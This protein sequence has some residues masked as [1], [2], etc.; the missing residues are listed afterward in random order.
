MSR[1]DCA[2]ATAELRAEL[3][4]ALSRSTRELT[5]QKTADMSAAERGRW[6]RQV[7]AMLKILDKSEGE[8]KPG[9]KAAPTAPSR[10]KRGNDSIRQLAPTAVVVSETASEPLTPTA[11]TPRLR[12]RSLAESD[13]DRFDRELQSVKERNFA[14]PFATRG[15]TPIRRDDAMVE[16]L[17]AGS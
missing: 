9:P 16:R 14:D 7:L 15:R 10:R 13:E 2:A 8:P 4:A 11:E 3:A 12:I 5:A 17:M 1:H 6:T